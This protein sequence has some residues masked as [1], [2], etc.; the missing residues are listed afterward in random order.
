M[1]LIS[2]LVHA[3]NLKTFSTTPKAV[4]PGALCLKV[5]LAHLL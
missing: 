3:G 1:F 2:G 4:L 5:V